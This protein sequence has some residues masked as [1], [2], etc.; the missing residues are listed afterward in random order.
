MPMN[1]S[2]GQGYMNSNM[3]GG[4]SMRNPMSRAPM[5]NNPMGNQTSMAYNPT[6]NPSGYS[7]DPTSG[8]TFSNFRGNIAQN[9]SRQADA[10]RQFNQSGNPALNNQM[11]PSPNRGGGMSMQPQMPNGSNAFQG[12]IPKAPSAAQ[13][14]SFMPDGPNAFQNMQAGPLPGYLNRPSG[15]PM[16]GPPRPFGL[17]GIQRP[18][19]PPQQPFQ[20]TPANPPGY[21]PRTQEQQSGLDGLQSMAE[22]VGDAKTQAWSDRRMEQNPMSIGPENAPGYYQRTMSGDPIYGQGGIGSQRAAQNVL[23]GQPRD[24]DTRMRGLNIPGMQFDP[25]TNSMVRTP[26]KPFKERV[27]MDQIRQNAADSGNPLGQNDGLIT[28]SP[29]QKWRREARLAGVRPRDMNEWQARRTRE[30]SG[31]MAI[32]PPRRQPGQTGEAQSLA[33]NAVSSPSRA[34]LL[35]G[36]PGRQPASDNWRQGSSQ[37]PNKMLE[38]R[39]SEEF[40]AGNSSVP[41]RNQLR[42]LEDAASGFFNQQFR[43]WFWRQVG[44]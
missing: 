25:N 1:Q 35:R 44:S 37:A 17:Q 18:P 32:G 29:E 30:A 20:A 38:Q 39:M 31:P 40:E 36:G 9:Q 21:W 8:Q 24:A 3:G 23:M 4:M 34:A 43:P 11:R 14:P 26:P 13:S 28:R 5:N 42:G 19:V 7:M 16:S 2:P 41:F 12:G 15:S 22:R 6:P 10:I 27:S 33:A